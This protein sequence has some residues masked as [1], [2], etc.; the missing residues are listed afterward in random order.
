MYVSELTHSLRC[1]ISKSC[2][3][4]SQQSLVHASYVAGT[5]KLLLSA[6]AEQVRKNIYIFSFKKTNNKTTTLQFIFW[7]A[8]VRTR[9]RFCRTIHLPACSPKD[10]GGR[11]GSFQQAEFFYWGKRLRDRWE[12]RGKKK[13]KALN[14]LRVK[15]E[16][17]KVQ[18]AQC[19]DYRSSTLSCCR[20]SHR[21]GGMEK[22][23]VWRVMKTVLN[24]G[25]AV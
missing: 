4:K 12:K 13:K 9:Q 22:D 14:K 6:R 24:L 18:T 23:E 16:N 3:S 8:I 1:P 19:A 15:S 11:C 7:N 5:A 2:C 10:R 21:W 17:K 25:E 20:S